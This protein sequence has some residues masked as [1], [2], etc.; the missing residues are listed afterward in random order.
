MNRRYPDRV[1]A[2]LD[3]Q[4]SLTWR[5][6]AEPTESVQFH[7]SRFEIHPPGK[8]RI[9]AATH[10][11]C[12]RRSMLEGHLMS[13]N[14]DIYVWPHACGREMGDQLIRC[15]KA[16]RKLSKKTTTSTNIWHSATQSV[17]RTRGKRVWQLSVP[18]Q[19]Y[20]ANGHCPQPAARNAESRRNSA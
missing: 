9:N 19:G 1:P 7:R 12:V 14:N 2:A 3:S 6:E 20:S 17:S 8:A 18:Q 11:D 13:A 4:R 5:T 15:S 10:T 16:C